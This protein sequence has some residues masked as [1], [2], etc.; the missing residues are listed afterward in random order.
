MNINNI[1]VN[2]SGIYKTGKTAA[3][4]GTNIGSASLPVAF[5]RF[6]G[7]ISSDIYENSKFKDIKSTKKDLSQTKEQQGLT[8]KLW[9]GIKNATGIGAGSKKAEKA[10]KNYEKGLISKDE[11]LKKVN[12][13]KEGQNM[14][15]DVVADITSGILSFGAFA[16]AVPTGG[17]S[18]AVGLGAATIVGAGA[19]VG[20]KAGDAISTGKEYTKK[21]LIY[22]ITTGAVNGLLTPVTNGIGNTVTK[23]IGKKIIRESAEEA[24]VQTTKQGFKQAVKSIILNQSD[25]IVGGSIGKR[26]IAFG[27]G[28]AAD[29]ALSGAADNMVRAGLNN[30][31]VF[32]ALSAA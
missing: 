9:D 15:V 3:L 11:M 13:Y 23:T 19:K 27:A 20:I 16:L 17:A 14:V 7:D 32:K 26:A 4:S 25:N 31:N 12:G 2:H 30:E 29:G 5:T 24:V 21:N 28:M 6:N 22:D 10:V 18:L 8:G 1:S